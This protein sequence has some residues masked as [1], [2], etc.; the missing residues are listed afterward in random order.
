[1]AGRAH[2][3]VIAVGSAAALCGAIGLFLMVI[4]GIDGVSVMESGGWAFA[5]L[6]LAFMAV[7][8][9]LNAMYRHRQDNG[10]KS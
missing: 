8:V 5:M 6:S 7:A 3:L 1:M 9:V 2:P 10:P 4:R